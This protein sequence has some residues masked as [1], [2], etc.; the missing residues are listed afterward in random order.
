MSKPHTLFVEVDK[1][2]VLYDE[3]YLC[4][5]AFVL[6]SGIKVNEAYAGKNENENFII[7]A[8]ERLRQAVVALHVYRLIEGNAWL[9]LREIT[10]RGDRYGADV[11]FKTKADAMLFKLCL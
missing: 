4:L 1:D 2:A 9:N 3:Q 11:E 7:A 8:Q 10:A 5:S 6:P